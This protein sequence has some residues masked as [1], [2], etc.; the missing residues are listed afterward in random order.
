MVGRRRCRRAAVVL[1]AKRGVLDPGPAKKAEY[2]IRFATTDAAKVW[3]DH[4][5]DETHERWQ[6]KPTLKGTDIVNRMKGSRSAVDIVG[7]DSD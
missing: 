2:G 1:A 6:H 7:M 5:G 4:A 3:K